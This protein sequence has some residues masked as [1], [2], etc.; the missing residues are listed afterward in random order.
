MSFFLNTWIKFFVLLTPFF[1]L[2]MFI[3]YTSEMSSIARRHLA[4]KVTLA[5]LLICLF[6]FFLGQP[7]FWVAGIT[8]DSFRVGAGILL[9]LSAVMLVH[10]DSQ[11]KP[12]VDD[13]A[14]VPLA[15][16][17]IVGPAT[18]GAILVMGAEVSGSLQNA[19][20]LLAL[21]L[22]I[23]CVGAILLAA[24]FIEKIVKRRGIVIMS[25]LTGLVLAALASQMVITGIKNLWNSQI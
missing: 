2:S 7:I 21:G 4:L 20:A 6:L 1:A 16:P 24:S 23:L 22:A 10:G 8:I 19:Q 3:L 13:L 11:V 18:I 15:V 12:A 25:K 5:V 14:V 17:I 9:F